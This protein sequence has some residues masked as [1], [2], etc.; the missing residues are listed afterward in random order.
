MQAWR[1]CFVCVCIVFSVFFLFLFL[2]QNDRN[3][4]KGEHGNYVRLC[5]EW[6]TGG[7]IC[8]NAIRIWPVKHSPWL[9]KSSL[10]YT[11]VT[12]TVSV[13]FPY[14]N[15]LFNYYYSIVLCRKFVSPYLHKVQQLQGQCY[16][17]LSVCAVFSCV[18]TMVG[19]QCLRFL[20]CTLML[21]HAIAHR[22]CIT[23]VR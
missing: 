19:C 12:L 8:V 2:R 6:K 5:A 22:G 3:C 13:S 15:I 9:Y 10:P 16:P 23:T 21:M 14:I 17:F 7:E 11:N 20:T 18:Q 1:I 4:Q